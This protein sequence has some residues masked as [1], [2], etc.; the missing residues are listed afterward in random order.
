MLSAECHLWAMPPAPQTHLPTFAIPV[1]SQHLQN[2]GI[3]LAVSSPTI[4]INHAKD[5]ERP[6]QMAELVP[7]QAEVTLGNLVLFQS[8]ESSGALIL[9]QLPPQSL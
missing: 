8:R 2:P 1:Y 3:P 4:P 7:L 5:L 6:P 9:S